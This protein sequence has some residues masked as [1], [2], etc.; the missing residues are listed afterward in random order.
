MQVTIEYKGNMHQVAHGGKVHGFM[1]Y[2]DAVVFVDYVTNGLKVIKTDESMMYF[3][4][5]SRL[6][7]VS[8][9]GESPKRYILHKKG[10]RTIEDMRQIKKYLVAA[11]L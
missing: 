4:D 1:H 5:G 8:L 11:E 3:N 7:D 6:V 10:N 2:N 9:K